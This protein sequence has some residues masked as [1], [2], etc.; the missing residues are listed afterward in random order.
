MLRK[1]SLAVLTVLT[2]VALFSTL[3]LA[4]PMVIKMGWTSTDGPTDSYAIAARHFK[5]ALEKAAPGQFDVQFFPKRKLGDEKEM[6]QKLSSGAMEM[7]LITN[8]PISEVEPAFGVNDLP[9]LYADEAQAHKVLDSAV[10]REL[11]AKLDKHN[12]VGLGFLEAGFRHMI[13]NVRPIVKPEDVAGIKWRVMESKVYVELFRALGAVAVPLAWGKAY[14]TLEKGEV[15]GM[16][17]PFTLIL[18]S[19]YYKIAKYLSLTKHTYSAVAML[20]SAKAWAQLSPEQQ[21]AFKKAAMT[22]IVAERR[23]NG[24]NMAKMLEQLKANGMQVNQVPDRA[25]FRVKLESLYQEFKP[26][27]GPELFD[28]FMMAVK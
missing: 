18:N 28:K 9:F 7:G 19:K 3:C 8:A 17:I 16:E 6:L 21:A 15:G 5:E 27:I 1:I 13:N 26:S 4:G 24:E 22:A 20:V 10:G 23:I 12:I 2:G 14:A 25:A 11:L